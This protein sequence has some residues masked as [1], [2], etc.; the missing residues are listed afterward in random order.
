MQ[1]PQS[2]QDSVWFAANMT[3]ILVEPHQT[4]E[5]FGATQVKYLI[6]SELLDDPGKTRVREGTV[7]SERPIILTPQHMADQLLE[8]FGEKAQEFADKLKSMGKMGAILQYGLQFRKEDVSEHLLSE[9]IQEVSQRLSDL[10]TGSTDGKLTTV[11]AGSDEMW[12]VSLLKF[13]I[14]YI[15]K[16]LPGNIQELRGNAH[17]GRLLNPQGARQDTIEQDF[18]M[19]RGS[20]HR[21]MALGEKLRRANLFQKY[22]DRFYALL[23]TAR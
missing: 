20:R 3:Q 17:T 13:M 10:H 22:E 9:P 12:E 19:A 1:T 5:T 4:L 14:D 21:V 8:G 15:Q 7:H 16:S 6:V 23:A 11:I 2:E 18:L